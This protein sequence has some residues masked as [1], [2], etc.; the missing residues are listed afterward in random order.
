MIG[1]RPGGFAWLGDPCQS[2][3]RP[4][5]LVAGGLHIVDGRTERTDEYACENGH[6][7]HSRVRTSAHGT[8]VHSELVEGNGIEEDARVHHV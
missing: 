2:C 7:Y 1:T 5:R 6:R 4:L 3:S 8:A